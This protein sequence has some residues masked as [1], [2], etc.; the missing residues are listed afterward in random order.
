LIPT[1]AGNPLQINVVTRQPRILAAAV[2]GPKRP[3]ATL[4]H[5]RQKLSTEEGVLQRAVLRS[6]SF[7][8]S[9]LELA[10]T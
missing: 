4:N 7:E 10:L 5:R 3:A 9:L 2:D 1:V 8:R 6:G